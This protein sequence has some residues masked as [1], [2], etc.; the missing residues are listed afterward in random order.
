MDSKEGKGEREMNWETGIDMY[1][2]L[3]IK[4]ANENLLY[5]TGIPVW[6]SIVT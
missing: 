1:I 3:C 4:I 2:Q 5:S 6:G